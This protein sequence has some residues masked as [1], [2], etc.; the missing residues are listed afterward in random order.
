MKTKF[1][2]LSTLFLFCFSFS[3]KAQ[4]DYYFCASAG[5]Y[6]L[7]LASLNEQLKG[8]G[9]TSGFGNA[10]GFGVD[11]GYKTIYNS[12]SSFSGDVT[13]ILTYN[14]LMPQKISSAGDSVKFQLNGYNMQLDWASFQWFGNDNITFTGGLAWAFGRL[15]VT[16][17]SAKGTTTYLNK[18]IGPEFRLEFNVRLADFFYVGLRYA[19]RDDIT[20]TGWKKSGVDNPDLTGTRMSGTMIGA[21]IG[22]GN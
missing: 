6:Y 13:G 16:E 20:K 17:N 11:W 14:Y 1:L 22:F 10:N 12:S 5:K 9:T 3:V 8:M 18:Y 15:K 7:P 21:F 2:F 4:N 19:Y